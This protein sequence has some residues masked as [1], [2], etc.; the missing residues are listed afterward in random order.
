MA[1]MQTKPPGFEDQEARAELLKRE[2]EGAVQSAGPNL[3]LRLKPLLRL[4]EGIGQ[5]GVL[6]RGGSAASERRVSG[7]LV[8]VASLSSAAFSA[9]LRRCTT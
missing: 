5:L 2:E 9:A 3:L 1:S 6:R 4:L 7:W 8:L